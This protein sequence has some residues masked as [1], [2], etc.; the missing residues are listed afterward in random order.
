MAV[1]LILAVDPLQSG[2]FHLHLILRLLWFWRKDVNAVGAD[3]VSDWAVVP[4]GLWE[5]A[6]NLQILV[7]VSAKSVLKGS[8]ITR[9]RTKI[10][11]EPKIHWKKSELTLQ[12]TMKQPERDVIYESTESPKQLFIIWTCET[13]QTPTC[14]TS[15]ANRTYFRSGDTEYLATLKLTCWKRQNKK[16]NI[17]IQLLLNANRWVIWPSAGPLTSHW[18]K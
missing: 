13:L 12:P 2:A 11:N 5:M 15:Y 7:N 10:F 4:H 9:S 3:S 14:L 6:T 16:T 8:V 1:S 17:I 18:Q